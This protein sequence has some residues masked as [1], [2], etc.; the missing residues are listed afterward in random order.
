MKLRAASGSPL[1]WCI[2]CLGLLAFTGLGAR[3]AEARIDVRLL[4]AVQNPPTNGSSLKLESDKDIIQ[5]L[6]S[7]KWTFYYEMNRTNIFAGS[8]NQNITLSS[9]CV[10]GVKQI[11][12][13]HFEIALRGKGTPVVRM[14]QKLPKGDVL[15]L[16]GAVPEAEST[17]WV[18][19]LKRAQ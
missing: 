16:A 7:F 17:A 15:V 4:W 11:T 5:K 12:S 6:S 9:N 19:V 2:L 18:I 8:A 10:I 14:L 1:A 3:A 13:S